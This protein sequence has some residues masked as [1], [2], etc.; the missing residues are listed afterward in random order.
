MYAEPKRGITDLNVICS[1][2]LGG[3]LYVTLAKN[4]AVSKHFGWL[5]VGMST[6]ISDRVLSRTAKFYPL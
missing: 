6:D 1:S 5:A 2:R 4:V 3:Q